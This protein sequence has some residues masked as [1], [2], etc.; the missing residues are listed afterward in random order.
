[1]VVSWLLVW[2]FDLRGGV[3]L[4]LKLFVFV[5]GLRIAFG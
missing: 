2:L 1:M 4:C 5:G 3:G